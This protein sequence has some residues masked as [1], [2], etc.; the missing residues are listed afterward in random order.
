MIP[1]ESFEP[2]SR[3]LDHALEGGVERLRHS[4]RRTSIRRTKLTKIFYTKN[5]TVP[6]TGPDADD[7]FHEPEAHPKTDAARASPAVTVRD[8]RP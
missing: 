5:L 2:S 6:E 8:L 3:P 7:L 1:N 4:I